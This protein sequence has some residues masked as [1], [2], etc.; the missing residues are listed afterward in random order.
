MV[1][2][3]DE[4]SFWDGLFFGDMLV[5]VREGI[6]SKMGLRFIILSPHL[7]GGPLPVIN[8]IITPKSSI[9]KPPLSSVIH[10]FWAIYRGPITTSMT[11][12]WAHRVLFLSDW[13]PAPHQIPQRQGPSSGTPRRKMGPYDDSLRRS[14]DKKTRPLKHPQFP[15][16]EKQQL[17]THFCINNAY[18][19]DWILYQQRLV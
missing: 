6:L 14:G 13:C 3:Q 17:T 4:I 15:R 18:A 19:Y 1:A 2:L 10:F 16:V 11:S 8:R 7:Q 12:H 5:S 9:K